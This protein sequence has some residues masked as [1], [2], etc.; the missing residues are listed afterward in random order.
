[1]ADYTPHPEY[2]KLPEAIKAEISDKEFAW[3]LDSQRDRLMDDF[4]CP[5]PD[6]DDEEELR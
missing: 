5:E 6:N 4:C 3:M 2:E 1:M